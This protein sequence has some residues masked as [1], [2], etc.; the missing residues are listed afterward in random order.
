M[1]KK[2]FC[3]IL[4]GRERDL[5]S[6]HWLTLHI[7]KLRLGQAEARSLE[8]HPVLPHDWWGSKKLMHLLLAP[9]CAF[10][11]SWVLTGVTR[12]QTRHSNTECRRPNQWLTTLCQMPSQG[13]S[14]DR[15][16]VCSSVSINRLKIKPFFLKVKLF[17]GSC[18]KSTTE[19]GV[20]WRKLS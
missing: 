3:F 13:P 12:T 6:M 18:L 20:S 17:L 2:R 4:K 1:F 8:L 11:G 15:T 7:H 10:A 5:S 16:S 9:R 19:Y 14:Y